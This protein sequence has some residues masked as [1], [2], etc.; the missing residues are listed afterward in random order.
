MARRLRD[1]AAKIAKPSRN[2][3]PSAHGSHPVAAVPAPPGPPLDPGISLAALMATV[4]SD[5]VFVVDAFLPVGLSL[6]AGK[7]KSGKSWLALQIAV[8]VAL[9]RSC[10]GSLPARKTAVLYLALEDTRRRLRNRAEVLLPALGWPA[11]EGLELRTA[12]PRASSGGLALLAE[13]FDAHPGG[14]VVLDTFA[15]FRDPAKGRGGTY[16]EDYEAVA[17]LK[18]VADLHKG[19]LLAVHHTRKGVADDPFDEISGTLG[20]NG[21]ADSLMV[22]DRE[23]GVGAGT[24]YL[25]GRDLPDQ[26][27]TLSWQP[28]GGVWSL[29]GRGD[30][31]TRPEKAEPQTKV[32]QCSTWLVGFLGEH[33][34]P[35]A[36]V[37]KAAADAGFTADNVRK[38]KTKLRRE[39]P[40]LCS[41]PAGSGGSWWNWIGEK[42]GRPPDRPTPYRAGGS[43]AP[44]SPQTPQ[45]GPR[46]VASSS[47]E[48]VSTSRVRVRGG[49]GQSEESEESEEAT[50]GGVCGTCRATVPPGADP[51]AVAESCDEPVCPYRRPQ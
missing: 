37:E 1:V 48:S 16:G 31:V 50:P 44:H 36:E 2:G 9:G 19:S 34:W 10:L 28:A 40:A 25:T 42:T 39:T 51:A 20:I 33:A 7:P 26:T 3:S 5:P 46:C 21:A 23:R 27:L 32:D 35:D 4:I 8:G 47:P 22:L 18:G 14:L 49:H 11:P 12:W 29:S 30:G 6:L 24:L 41:R 45:T 15:R 17:G 38:A 13:W 43:G